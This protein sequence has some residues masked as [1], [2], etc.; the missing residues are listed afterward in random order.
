MAAIPR[1]EAR[2]I[3]PTGKYVGEGFDDRLDNILD[4]TFLDGYYEPTILFL[5]EPIKATAGR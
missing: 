1:D 4:F 3:L 2:V 5:Y